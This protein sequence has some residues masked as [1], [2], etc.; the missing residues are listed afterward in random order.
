GGKKRG[1]KCNFRLAKADV[2]ANEP[3][4]RPSSGKIVR[5]GVDSVLLVLGFV[6]RKARCEVA[7][8]AIWRHDDR[9]WTHLPLGRNRDELAGHLQQAALEFGLARSPRHAAELVES[10]LGRIRAKTRQ[11]LNVLYRQEQPVITGIDQFKTVVRRTSGF[12]RSQSDESSDAVIGVNNDITRRQ[13]RNFCNEIR[14]FLAFLTTANEAI[15][16]NIL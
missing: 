12:D 9:S 6:V 4:H 7:V 13:S 1:A 10:D 3:V 5:H 14:S 8:D 11:K 2:A 15:A 16:E